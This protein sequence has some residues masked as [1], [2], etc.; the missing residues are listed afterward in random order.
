M[1]A[2]KGVVEGTSVAQTFINRMVSD[3]V[4]TP[5]VGKPTCGDSLLDIYLVR[6]D[7]ELISCE[8]VQ[9]ISDHCRVLLEVEWEVIAVRLRGI[10]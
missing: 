7:C 10:D 5:V 8:T 3:N 9:E 1:W 4:Y 2:G 6:P